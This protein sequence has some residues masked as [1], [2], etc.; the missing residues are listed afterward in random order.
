MT[1]YLIAV[2]TALVTVAGLVVRELPRLYW[3]S[4][5]IRLVK[6]GV[7]LAVTVA[8]VQDLMSGLT[9]AG[10][11]CRAAQ[12]DRAPGPVRHLNNGER[13]E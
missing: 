10:E 4:G 1:N 6:K 13:G 5:Q 8:D 12:P 11:L 9:A 2:V 3:L 7:T